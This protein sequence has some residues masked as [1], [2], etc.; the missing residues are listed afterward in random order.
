MMKNEKI[1]FCALILTFLITACKKKS[2]PDNKLETGTVTDIEGNIYQTVKIGDQWWMAENLKTKT[3]RNGQQIFALSGGDPDSVWGTKTKGLYCSYYNDAGNISKYGMLYNWYAVIDTSGVAPVGWHVATD[4]DWKK[5][6]MW[7]GM[8]ES[9]AN[10]VNWRG[11]HEADLLKIKSPEDWT[12]YGNVWSTNK[13][14]FSAKAGSC[15]VFNGKWG[16][17]SFGGSGFWWTSSLRAAS[18]EPYYRYMD[19]KKSNIFRF[20]GPRSYGMSIRCVKD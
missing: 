15:R 8:S 12:T 4:D 7:V 5:L 14:G 3:Y 11:S 9:D 2:A 1:F 20:Y 13:S 16:V 19:Y 10:G 17:P 18:G 6:E